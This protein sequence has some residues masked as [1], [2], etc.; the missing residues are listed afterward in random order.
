MRTGAATDASRAYETAAEYASTPLSQYDALF[1]KTRA[2]QTDEI[3]E[4]MLQTISRAE[5][6]ELSW[7]PDMKAGLELSRLSAEWWLGSDDVSMVSRLRQLTVDEQVRSGTRLSS[8]VLGMAASDNFLDAEG[9]RWF[10]DAIAEIPSIEEADEQSR[11]KCIVIYETAV[12][13]LHAAE[14]AGRK[15]IASARQLND[16]A[17]LINAMRFAHYPARRLGDF[18]AAHKRLGIA[19]ELADRFKRPHARAAIA[20]LLA[21]LHLDYGYCEQAIAYTHQVTDHPKALGGAFRQQSALDTRALALCMC[22]RHSEARAIVS[23]SETILARGKRRVQFMSLAASLLV[24]L[25][26]KADREIAECLNAIDLVRDRLFR[27][28]GHDLIAIAYA[29]GLEYSRGRRA[30]AEFVGWYL[31]EARR[32]RLPIPGQLQAFVV[33]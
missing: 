30:A 8:A 27:H 19:A 5:A 1:G 6:L 3:W 11:L 28:T 18:D 31:A 15:L 16:Q 23:P 29:G 20:D 12:G 13:D 22:G 32:D 24:A 4:E 33:A 10:Y 9:I 26:D 7:T 25:H 2:Q 14:A 17:A 21:G